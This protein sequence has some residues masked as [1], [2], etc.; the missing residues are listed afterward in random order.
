LSRNRA[1]I[2]KRAKPSR[3]LSMALPPDD[4]T[5]AVRPDVSKSFVGI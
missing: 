5:G 2:A 1:M 4:G 3:F